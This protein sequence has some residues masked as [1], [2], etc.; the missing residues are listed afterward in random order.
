M[1]R[2]MISWQFL[3]CLRNFPHLWNPKVHYRI[4]NNSPLVSILSQISPVHALPTNLFNVRFNIVFPCT[5]KSSE[6]SLYLT[7]PHK[8]PVR[9]CPLP[10]ACYM[11]H[12]SQSASFYCF[13]WF[14]QPTDCFQTNVVYRLVPIMVIDCSLCSIPIGPYN[15]Y[16]L[17]SL[18]YTDWPL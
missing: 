12:P 3:G 14:S 15:G 10:Y 13:V 16:R 8:T 2:S 7:F 1:E 4:H 9:I 5:S 18:Q 17:F 6:W 11:P